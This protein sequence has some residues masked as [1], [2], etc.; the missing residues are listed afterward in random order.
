[1]KALFED[2]EDEGI[3]SWEESISRTIFDLAL[4]AA[5]FAVMAEIRKT[6]RAVERSLIEI[7]A[8]FD[9]MARSNPVL[10][11][12]INQR[13]YETLAMLRQQGMKEVE[14]DKEGLLRVSEHALQHRSAMN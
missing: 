9:R 6:E 13:R 14:E 4:T 7:D 12:S 11:E 10:A 8:A 1:M 5:L 3:P 2:D